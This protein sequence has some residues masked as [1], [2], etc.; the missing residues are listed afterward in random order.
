[1]NRLLTAVLLVTSLHVLADDLI[2]FKDGDVIK[3]EDFNHNFQELEADIAS[4]PAGATGP[5]G[6]AGATGPRGPQGEQGPAGAAGVAAGLACNTNQLIEYDG[7]GW[8]CTEVERV[9]GIDEQASPPYNNPN[10]INCATCPA[11]KKLTGGA[12]IHYTSAASTRIALASE[13]MYCCEVANNYDA[14][15]TLE[16][17]AYCL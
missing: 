12:C 14:T 15:T 17:V 16:S 11:G 7:S 10:Y 4:I 2:E 3:A 5:A 8:V 9:M 13:D 6:P 1:M